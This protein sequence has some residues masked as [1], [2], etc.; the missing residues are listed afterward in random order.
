MSEKQI[1]DL[2]PKDLLQ[3]PVWY[4]PMDDSVEDELSVKPCSADDLSADYQVIVRTIFIDSEGQ[5][6]LGYIY[7]NNPDNI[8]DL[9][10]VLFLND[11]DCITFW[12]GMI[13]PSWSDYDA[14]LHAIKGRFPITFRSDAFDSFPSISG[15][16]NG[17]YFLGD[18]D[19]IQYI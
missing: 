4:F 14:E 19:S 15:I 3:H 1:Y 5:E 8:E 11:W 10:P 9:K 18:G 2:G 7:W 12:N 16:L 13:K 17:L 6:N